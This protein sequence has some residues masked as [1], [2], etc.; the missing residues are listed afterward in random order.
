GDDD[1]LR[2]RVGWLLD[3]ARRVGQGQPRPEDEALYLRATLF[4]GWLGDAP[5]VEDGLRDLGAHILLAR[6]FPPG[7]PHPLA[8]VESLARGHGLASLSS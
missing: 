6:A 3:A 8:V 1:P 4:G 2:R 7:A 5:S